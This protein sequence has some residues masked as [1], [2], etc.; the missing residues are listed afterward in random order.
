MAEIAP[1]DSL[2]GMA[3]DMIVQVRGGSALTDDEPIQEI[4]VI[5]WLRNA[6]ATLMREEIEK[7]DEQDVPVSP[8]FYVNVSTPITEDANLDMGIEFYLRYFDSMLPSVPMARRGVLLI[9]EMTLGE[10]AAAVEVV[11]Q[12]HKLRSVAKGWGVVPRPKAAAFLVKRTIRLCLPEFLWNADK[13][14]TRMVPSD[15]LAGVS[16]TQS[17]PLS[18]AWAAAMKQRVMSTDMAILLN[19]IPDRTNDSQPAQSQPVSK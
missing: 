16:D 11:E 14:V 19:G 18:R 1:P 8:E 13:L 3:I 10:M 4:Q 9:D 2:Y 6:A 5:E 7:S 15:P 17:I 12:Q